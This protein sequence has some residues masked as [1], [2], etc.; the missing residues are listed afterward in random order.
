VKLCPDCNN[1]LPSADF[2]KGK[3]NKDGLQRVCRA[4]ERAHYQKNKAR[5]AERNHKR[6]NQNACATC[7]VA[8]DNRS[9][10]CRNCNLKAGP[11]H[12]SWKGSDVGYFRAHQRIRSVNDSASK[13]SCVECGESAAEWCYNHNDPNDRQEMYRGYVLTYSCD[14]NY[15]EPRCVPCHRQYDKANRNENLNDS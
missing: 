9:T 1:Q 4:C 7:G 5:I 10:Q 8:C 2:N 15:Y 12:P 13:H 14:P 3:R 11:T 6:R